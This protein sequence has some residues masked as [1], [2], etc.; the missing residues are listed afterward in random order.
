MAAAGLLRSS[1][2]TL[3]TT[4][5]ITAIGFI[6]SVITARVLGPEGR[7]LLSAALLIATLGGNIALFG[8][9]NSFIYHKGTGRPF[10]YKLFMVA[11]LLFAAGFSVLIGYFGLQLT[12]ETQLH[13]QWLLILLLTSIT[14]TQGYFYALSQL[15]AKL[16][17]FNLMRF[18][19]VAGNL[20]LL[21]G[22]LA[23][24]EEVDFRKILLTQTIVSAVLTIMGLV[25]AGQNRVWEGADHRK[26]PVS[27]KNMLR[28][29]VSHH[30]TVVLGLLLVNFDKVALLNI[31]TIIEYGFY[32]LA[33]TT[34]R[35]IGAL[36]E[37]VS[38]ALYS[39]FAG[40]DVDE[41]SRHV[42]VAFRL[43]FVPMLTLAAIG[44]LLSP[45]LIVWVYG[46]SFAPT[47][48]PFAVLLFECVIAG[49]SWTLA[50]R[51]NAGGRPGLVF[52]RQFISVL[53][54]FMAL[55]FLPAE[56]IHVYLSLLML[57]GA[58]LRLSVTMAIYPL[59]LKETLPDVLPT[60][61]DCKAV[62]R[63]LTR[64]SFG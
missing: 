27:W 49:A 63:L 15:Q 42:R 2:N 43:T 21:L 25:W 6:T 39:R 38:T 17:F 32:A 58:V 18:V 10:N 45:W 34:S 28:Y 40:K 36:Q 20:I 37:A 5:V 11:S 47:V 13:G 7:G 35:L 44:A 19:L 61:E 9:A 48:I 12:S 52:M 54:V 14:A 8:M 62:F 29:G 24:Y 57:A 26:Q 64:R 46:D 60:V 4:V 50:Q 51:F 55:P 1:G 3:A 53:P 30:G 16:H 59:V 31:G 56:N 41:L 22:L 23:F 33:F